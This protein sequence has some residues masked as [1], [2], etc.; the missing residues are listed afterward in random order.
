MALP[1][2]LII[3]SFKYFQF[4]SIQPL[5]V[6]LNTKENG[7]AWFKISKLLEIQPVEFLLKGLENLPRGVEN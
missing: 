4:F 1:G 3:K 5:L 6:T 7:K 2:F